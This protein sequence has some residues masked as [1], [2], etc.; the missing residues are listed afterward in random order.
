ME[1]KKTLRLQGVDIL[2]AMFALGKGTKK[3][4]DKEQNDGKPAMN[5][6]YVHTTLNTYRYG[7]NKFCDY[8]ENLGK[9]TRDLA[10]VT[11]YV[12]PFVDWLVAAKYGPTTVHTWASAVTKVLGLCLSDYR[13]PKRER[14]AIK[15]SRYPVK[16]DARF[17]PANHQELVEFCRSVGP[18]NHKELEHIAGT[19]LVCMED[20]R[21]AVDIKKGKGGKQRYAPIYGPPERVARVVKMMNAAGE[22]LLFDR[23]PTAADIHSYRAEYACTVYKTHARPINELSP[24]EKYICR[25]DLKGTVYDREAM[26]IASKALGHNRV[27]VI[28]LAYLWALEVYM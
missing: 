24:K 23:I 19:D 14:A 20:G 9:H 3:H 4:L 16:S 7:W 25:K 2:K 10:E 6:I 22:N 1:R 12:Q 5:K 13:L 18:R 27:D 11:K 28:A 8:L 21:F 26:L 17:C 15:R